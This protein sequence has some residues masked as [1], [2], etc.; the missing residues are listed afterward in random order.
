MN[1]LRKIGY[2]SAF[3][4]PALVVTGYQ[5]GGFWNFLP[6]GFVFVVVPLADRWFGLDTQNVAAEKEELIAG[7]FYYRF[8]TYAWLLVQSL[9]F[10]WLCFVMAGPKLRSALDWILF[11]VDFGLVTGGIGITV[12]HE[13][14]HKKSAFDRFCSQFLLMMVFYMHFYIE[15][16]RGHHVHV[17][18]PQDPATAARGQNA[19][20]F[21]WQSVSGSWQ[22]AWKLEKEQLLRK[23]ASPWGLKNR[24]LLYSIL[25]LLFVAL[26]TLVASVLAG[27]W[28]WEMPLFVVAQSLVAITLLE[29]VN[30][31]EHYG[32]TRK[33]LAP[34]QFEKVNPLHSWNSSYAVSNF[35]LFQL[36]RHSDHHYHA[37][38]RYQVLSHFNE[39]PQLPFGY[40]AMI[41]VALIPPL[42]FHTMDP[43]LD[44]WKNKTLVTQQHG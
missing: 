15:H 32:I 22:H 13:L 30:Y 43:L 29:L 28:V 26:L 24:M 19:Y 6:I 31:I 3:I 35:F 18:T 33:E 42:W 5:F 40:P 7:D 34:G 39:S 25:P 2:L 4:L 20:K 38:K 21:W 41:L 36:Q 12:A 16:N 8:V 14:G 27:R 11:T 23:G 1:V 17:A 37:S 9:L 10:A 44:T